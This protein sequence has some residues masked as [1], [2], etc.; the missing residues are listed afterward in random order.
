ILRQVLNRALHSHLSIQHE[1]E[2]VATPNNSDGWIWR[3]GGKLMI[4]QASALTI[5]DCPSLKHS[6][7]GEDPFHTI[8]TR[9]IEEH[10]EVGETRR[11]P[12]F[13]WFGQRGAHFGNRGFDNKMVPAEFSL[14]AH[15]GASPAHASHAQFS[16]LQ[17]KTSA[18]A[19]K[20]ETLPLAGIQ[21]ITVET[22]R[23]FI[24][25]GL[26]LGRDSTEK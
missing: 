10:R 2:L 11:Q 4:I 17:L 25:L 21:R 16:A 3:L 22:G 20:A 18:T 7:A 15:T 1:H 26:S 8:T 24:G 23:P 12:R 19:L 14:A 9:I 5:H 6:F 13:P